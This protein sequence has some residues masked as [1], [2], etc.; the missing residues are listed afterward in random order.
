MRRFNYLRNRPKLT[1]IDDIT[2]LERLEVSRKEPSVEFLKELHKAHLHKIP[3]ENLEIQFGRTRKWDISSLFDQ[4]IAKPNRGGLGLELNSLF[5]HL[6]EQLGFQCVPVS[7]GSEPTE[8]GYGPHY[9]HLV[10][11]VTL[12]EEPWLADVGS[13]NGPLLPK[14]M[15][16]NELQVDYNR[17]MRMLKDPDENWL[18]QISNDMTHF[19]TLYGF[20]EKERQV[21]EFIDKHHF[22]QA[23][24]DSFYVG[25]KFVQKWTRDGLITLTGRHIANTSANEEGRPILN[26]DEFLSKLEE[27]YAIKLADLIQ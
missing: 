2:Y 26:E 13:R 9:E 23:D 18:L 6:L 21:I 24:P 11:V 4:I 3:H 22:Y 10:I 27:Y 14:K 8:I 5:Y 25:S 1:K 20:A 17:Y 15:V 16:E 7:A 19:S 12:S